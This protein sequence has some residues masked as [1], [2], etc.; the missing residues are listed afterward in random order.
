MK[1]I[2][3]HSAK[4]DSHNANA[5]RVVATANI[6]GQVLMFDNCI[7]KPRVK[8]WQINTDLEACNLFTKM[9]RTLKNL[10]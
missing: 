4:P 6:G 5:L 10:N 1:T 3:T 7:L 9:V 8:Y 2:L